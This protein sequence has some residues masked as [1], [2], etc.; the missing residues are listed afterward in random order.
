MDAIRPHG[1]WP[2]LP[3]AAGAMFVFVTALLF[4]LEPARPSGVRI[5]PDGILVPA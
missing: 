2:G 4:R 1:R 5:R 3:I